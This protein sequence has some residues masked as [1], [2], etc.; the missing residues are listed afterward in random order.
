VAR[1][2]RRNA[3]YIAW[4]KAYDHRRYLEGKTAKRP[5][6]RSAYNAVQWALR[7]GRLV[8]QPCEVCGAEQ[9][10]AHHDDYD[11]PLQVRWLCRTHHVEAEP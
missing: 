2:V 3:A 10:E 11:K 4:R 9:T 5:E 1:R 6:V 8:R 7:T